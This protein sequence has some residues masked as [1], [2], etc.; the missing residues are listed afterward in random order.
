MERH[1]SPAAA[2]TC[3]RPGPPQPLID[4]TAAPNL[5]GYSQADRQRRLRPPA[6]GTAASANLFEAAPVSLAV[7]V[8]PAVP[9]AAMF[10]EE[11]LRPLRASSSGQTPGFPALRFAPERN[12]SL[13]PALASRSGGCPHPIAR[14][15]SHR[16]LLR[17]RG[18]GGGLSV[19]V[20][21]LGTRPARRRN[22]NLRELAGRGARPAPPRCRSLCGRDADWPAGGRGGVGARE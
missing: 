14:R 17:G 16:P 22:S 3:R 5:C 19:P 18:Q 2:A 11:P 13:N 10:E 20:G 6:I 15:G 21:P 1:G 9:V 8:F 7:P 4:G 12:Q